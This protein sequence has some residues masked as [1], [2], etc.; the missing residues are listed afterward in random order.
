MI[1]PLMI[2]EPIKHTIILVWNKI[3]E[4]LEKMKMHSDSTKQHL[5]Q[6]SAKETQLLLEQYDKFPNNWSRI[7]DKLIHKDEES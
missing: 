7:A 1:N 4:F 2:F 5:A 6:W 3:K